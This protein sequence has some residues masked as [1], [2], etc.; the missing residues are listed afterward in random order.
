MMGGVQE[1]VTTKPKAEAETKKPEGKKPAGK[2]NGT[3][4]VAT[5]KADIPN[6]LRLKSKRTALSQHRVA[7]SS[8]NDGLR[9]A[10]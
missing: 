4:I 10:S 6:D 9:V 5:N 2:D 3:N 8:I 1:L 7:G